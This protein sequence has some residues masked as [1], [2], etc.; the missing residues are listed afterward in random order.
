MPT[1]LQFIQKTFVKLYTLV[2]G[3]GGNA[4]DVFSF[5]FTINNQN[6]YAFTHSTAMPLILQLILQDLVF[7]CTSHFC[8]AEEIKTVLALFVC[9]FLRM[10]GP[11]TM[12]KL[13][14]YLSRKLNSKYLEFCF[15]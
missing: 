12:H 3:V 6:P 8:D 11:M 9:C 1:V 5:V 15:T 14:K 13:I 10:S 7:T 4:S 2:N